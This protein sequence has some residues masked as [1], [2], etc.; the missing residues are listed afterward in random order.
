MNPTTKAKR[1]RKRRKEKEEESAA[2]ATGYPTM[3]RTSGQART[4]GPMLENPARFY[5]GSTRVGQVSPDIRP[6]SPDI[7]HPYTNAGRET[8]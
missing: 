5:P 2:T 6:P 4:S 7:R 8:M 3:S 1:A